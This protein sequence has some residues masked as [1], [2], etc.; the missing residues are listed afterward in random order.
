MAVQWC[1]LAGRLCLW[2]QLKEAAFTPYKAVHASAER[3]PVCL[4]SAFLT[5]PPAPCPLPRRFLRC[6][7]S[8]GRFTAGGNEVIGI[9]LGTTNS[10]VA[11]MEGKASDALFSTAGVAHWGCLVALHA[12][13]AWGWWGGGRALDHGD[14]VCVPVME[15]KW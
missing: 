7:S 3:C 12:V 2:R 5:V 6:S 15:G 13:L 14:Q 10:C 8:V 4:A 9:D 1:Q 11:V